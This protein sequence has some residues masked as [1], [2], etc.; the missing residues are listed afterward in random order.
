MREFVEHTS[1]N[2]QDELKSRTT[3]RVALKLVLSS[4]KSVSHL[5][6]VAYD[7]VSIIGC[8][9]CVAII[10]AA[11]A[12][13]RYVLISVSPSLQILK[14]LYFLRSMAAGLCKHDG[15]TAANQAVIYFIFSATTR[16][17][18]RMLSK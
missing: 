18:L 12:H 9:R 8:G 1:S 7:T 4:L 11:V 10:V 2:M 3:G 14:A 13:D 5:V 17:S 16:E 6:A 15:V